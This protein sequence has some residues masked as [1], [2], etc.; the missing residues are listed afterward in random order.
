MNT[1]GFSAGAKAATSTL[2][3]MS[4]AITG[5][6]AGLA[7][8][9]Q[10][11]MATLGGAIGPI[12]AML[13]G[14]LAG[15]NAVAAAKEALQAQQKLTAVLAATGGAAGLT[16]QQIADYASE[17]QRVTNFEDDAT[18]AAAA[19]LA[20]FK[21][22]SGENFKR[23]IESAM[24][25]ST[26]FETDL[27]SSIVQLGKAL[28]DPIHG[29]AQLRKAGIQFT[30]QQKKQIEVLQRTGN[31][32]GAQGV[33]LD[34]LSAKFGGAAKAVADPWVQMQN[35]IGDLSES[36]GGALLPIVNSVARA[37]TDFANLLARIPN[38]LILV[39]GGLTAL[40]AALKAV[41]IGQAIVKGL[42]G[43][44]GWAA[45]AAGIA[46]AA[47]AGQEVA[48]SFR[49]VA[50]ESSTSRAAMAGANHEIREAASAANEFT[51]R[52]VELAGEV[53]SLLFSQEV[54][55]WHQHIDLAAK[56][57]ENFRQKFRDIASEMNAPKGGGL[58]EQFKK[59]LSYVRQI[60]DV[61]GPQLTADL[62]KGLER[63][64]AESSGIHEAI[65][66]ANN[67]R[68]VTEGFKTDHDLTIE[69]FRESGATNPQL[70]ELRRE[71][72]LLDQARKRI[73]GEKL[74]K[75]I[76][77]QLTDDI[78]KLSGKA[79]EA[80][81][82]LRNMIRQGLP[83]ADIARA[84]KMLE[85]RAA[86]SKKEDHKEQRRNTPAASGAVVAG[87]HE[88]ASIIANAMNQRGDPQVRVA[89]KSLQE[90]RMQNKLLREVIQELREK[91]R[92]VQQARI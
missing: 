28:N 7:T 33:I 27:Q 52:I 56:A 2:G 12:G 68:Q 91:L 16:T 36:I 72:T 30:E 1:A 77:Q 85:E 43:P 22:L 65:R 21:N 90:E 48:A 5:K 20:V 46:I 87:S 47:A 42:S 61:L 3:S 8:G 88:A 15:G 92:P 39:V 83:E 17:L 23:T 24:D 59:A 13:G 29:L 44:A 37:M 74:S 80:E 19:K 40:V 73:E 71:L 32:A 35:A 55:R 53:D 57:G 9:I 10:A 76:F 50:N 86:L 62:T 4:S 18:V 75:N 66:N 25:L 54:L 79:S 64:L 81:I 69:K 45:L 84:R 51:N 63:K 70:M 89:E 14:A 31:L 60:K 41:A 6:L 82:E 34:E 26:V 38:T 78:D 67:Q 11:N 58:A 49:D